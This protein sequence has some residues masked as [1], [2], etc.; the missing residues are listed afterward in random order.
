MTSPLAKVFST[1][2]SW[3]RALTDMLTNPALHAQKSISHGVEQLNK[4]S[5]DIYTGNSKSVLVG[6]EQKDAAR[7]RATDS[8]T[9][10]MAGFGGIIVPIT[11]VPKIT[12]T[13]ARDI[14]QEVGYD[15]V[16]AYDYH[17]AYKQP[18]TGATVVNI[19]DSANRV[20]PK[21]FNTD[22]AT[23]ARFFDK[24]R[25]G[26]ETPTLADIIDPTGLP[27]DLLQY[28]KNVQVRLGGKLNTGSFNPRSDVIYLGKTSDIDKAIS[29]PLHEAQ[30][31][32]QFLYDMPQGGSPGDFFKNN[33]NFKNARAIVDHYY[34][35]VPGASMASSLTPAALADELTRGLT[36]RDLLNNP[37]TL[38]A[39]DDVLKRVY[40]N[41][42]DKY[43]NL[44]G[45]AEARLV[46]EL[47]LSPD[48]AYQLP[49]A[50]MRDV[51]RVDPRQVT[52]R[53]EIPKNLVDADPFVEKLISTI[54][55]VPAIGAAGAKP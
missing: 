34:D 11:S 23:G 43:E 46:Q 42:F 50:V 47:L 2:D 5:A 53:S 20:H 36:T 45:E 33:A 18:R 44:A 25:T 32:A 48:T 39:A 14:A 37:E 41:S 24:T 30:H 52:L 38:N 6:K 13:K 26:K 4:L 22:Q 15:P 9:N 55:N 19:P 54:L 28:F 21:Y 16:G 51:M 40:L 10:F 27:R 3:K 31:V 17:R 29:I 8:M 49:T 12:I 7:A 35:R 1:A